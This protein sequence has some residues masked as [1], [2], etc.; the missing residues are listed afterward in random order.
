MAVGGEIGGKFAASLFCVLDSE[1]DIS[2]QDE[3][4]QL[5]SEA[6]SVVAEPEDSAQEPST[7][8]AESSGPRLVLKPPKTPEM[9]QSQQKLKLKFP[10]RQSTEKQEFSVDKESLRKQQELVRAGSNGMELPGQ[11]PSRNLRSRSGSGLRPRTTSSAGR[12]TQDREIPQNMPAPS[13]AQQTVK[14]EAATRTPDLSTITPQNHTYQPHGSAPPPSIPHNLTPANAPRP[15]KP[16]EI[17]NAQKGRIER[18]KS[19]RILL[20]SMKYV[21]S[22]YGQISVTP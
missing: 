22:R 16:W 11:T 8:A 1:T 17:Y 6:K 15:L 5:I 2:H 14:P 13:P 4:L 12:S 18:G 20:I 9:P 10:T 21:F 7:S 19:S 3:F